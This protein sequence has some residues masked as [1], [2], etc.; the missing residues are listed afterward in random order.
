LFVYER[1]VHFEDVDAARI[2][3]FPTVLAYC[4]EAMAALMA[5]ID[6]GYA[7]LVVD[8]G[9]GLPTVHVHVDFTAPLRFGDQAKIELQVARIG[10]R[11]CT[12][13]LALS[14]TRDK[15][16][17]AKVTLICACTDLTKLRSIP[18][19]DD[20]RQILERHRVAA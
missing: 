9:I 6:G 13:E 15:V 4:H 14:R 19:P 1:A 11:S 12:F 18:W 16:A 7:A 17:A 3:F 5:E 20:V 8:R 2:V 10:A